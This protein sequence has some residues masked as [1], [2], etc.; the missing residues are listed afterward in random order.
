MTQFF[1]NFALWNDSAIIWRRFQKHL[2][3]KEEIDYD[4]YL[5]LKI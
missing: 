1:R 3:R 4:D 2:L 5:L